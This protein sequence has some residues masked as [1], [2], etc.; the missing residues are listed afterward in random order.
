MEGEGGGFLW[1][2]GREGGIGNGTF[3]QLLSNHSTNALSIFV[4]DSLSSSSSSFSSSDSSMPFSLFGWLN[5]CLLCDC[6]RTNL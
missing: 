1:E 4:D 2:M 3:L 6:L 5:F